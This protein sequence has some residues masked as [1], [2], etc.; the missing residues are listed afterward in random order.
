MRSTLRPEAG[1]H[2]RHP[3]T[4]FFAALVAL[5]AGLIGTAIMFAALRQLE[6]DKVE[7][8]FRQRANLRIVA[9]HQQLEETVQVLKVLNQ[10]F[11][12]VG[13]VTREQFQAFT[14][15]LLQRHPYVQAFNFHRF[16]SN[17]ERPEYETA[18]RKIYPDFEIKQLR[19]G[20][21][22]SAAIAERH[23]LVDYIEPMHGNEAAFGLDVSPNISLLKA[24]RHATDTGKV[25]STGLLTLA[26]GGGK[27]RGFLVV[28]PV[29]R[30]GVPPP[31]VESRRKAVIGDTA[32]VFNASG[33]IEKILDTNGL[34]NDARIGIRVH[35]GGN[36]DEGS[37]AFQKG[38]APDASSGS[39]LLPQWMLFDRPPDIVHDFDVAGTPWRIVVS[40]TPTFFTD[41][42]TG[43]LYGLIAGTLFS[44]L[45]AAYVQTLASRSRRV[46]MLVE[47]RT[48]ELRLANERLSKDIAARKRAED[49]LLL[50]QRAIEASAN[51]III[52]SV[53]APDYAIE[54]VNPAFERITGY[55]AEEVIGRSCS[56]LW[57]DDT[58]QPEL[59]GML[60]AAYEKREGHAILRGYGKG[61]RPFWSDTYLA[62][63]RDGSNEVNH[64]VVALYDITATKRYQAELEYQA[65]R[66]SLTGLANRNLL[67]DRLR[68]ASAYAERYGHPVWVLFLNLDRFKF[69]NDTLGHRAGDSL[70]KAVA[71]RLQNAVRSTDTVARLSADEFVLVLTERTDEHLSPVVVQRI[72]DAI[73]LP[74]V[75]EGYEF[76]MSSSIGLS[77]CP[78]DGNDPEA[79]I[80][81]ASIAMYRAKEVGR[82]CFQFYTSSMNEKALERLRI[83]S[84]LRSALERNEFQLHYQPQVDLSSGQILGVEALI[85]WRHP[86]LGMVAPA[87]FIQTAEEMG[88]IVPIGTWVLRTACRQSVEW[89]RGGMGPVRVAVNLSARQFYQHDLVATIEDVLDETGIAPHLLELELTESMML[90]D[91]ENAVAIMR[92]LKALGVHLS[93]DD[94]GTGYSSLS[95]LKRFPIDLLKIDRSFV[96]DV[97]ADADDA[98]IVRSIISLAHSLR[99]KVIAEG[100]ET[101]GQFAY[102]Q[103]HGCDYMQGYF[104]SRPLDASGAEQ[105]LRKQLPK[106]RDPDRAL[107]A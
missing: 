9:V 11:A 47:Q 104:Y 60:A 25:A 73:A 18:M 24:I 33:L 27:L 12:T 8:E 42:H 93:I 31:D 98:A 101:E 13:S 69:V 82:N 39:S 96:S 44:L 38:V 37:V 63:V 89:Q 88:L 14:E 45:L 92:S 70:L 17:E 94:F 77:V 41:R 16:V 35:V 23:L 65:N 78:T 50:R 62:P 83:E 49:G 5:T 43:S 28:M 51:A 34:L 15:P 84:D 86:T 59:L 30:D 75:I 32:A 107:P 106:Q 61:G 67:Q 58:D 53:Q 4:I 52:T 102:L 56:L 74:I 91:V 2:S 26:Q 79:L 90:T 29:Y 105:L 68:Q 3:S 64:F 100:V 57:A 72:I 55:R 7:L 36:L 40:S 66:D 71:D 10:F 87:S 22:V 48:A 54:Y 103:R 76:V 97:T 85:R 1:T 21:L 19:D 6:H 95:Y 20:R 46:Q 99:L 80:K 81:H